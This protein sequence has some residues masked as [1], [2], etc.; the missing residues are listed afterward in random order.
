M[1]RNAV[2]TKLDVIMDAM[3]LLVAG[4]ARLEVQHDKMM[5]IINRSIEMSQVTSAAIDQM[6]RGMIERDM[7]MR[8][9]YN[10]ILDEL[11]KLKNKAEGGAIE[12]VNIKRTL[13]RYE[14]QIS[15]IRD[16]LRKMREERHDADDEHITQ[17]KK[18]IADRM[19]G[20]AGTPLSTKELK[21]LAEA[22]NILAEAEAK[23]NNEKRLSRYVGGTEIRVTP[24]K[25]EI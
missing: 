5:H 11:V 4:T 16:A 15:K 13:E 18:L 19:A 20:D 12:Q 3:N 10:D 25:F 17:M 21:D 6:E 9:R 7:Q 22:A 1:N 23:A 14:I 8:D 2:N 24:G